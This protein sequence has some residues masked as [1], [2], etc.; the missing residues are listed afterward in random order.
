MKNF[1]YIVILGTVLGLWGWNTY[2]LNSISRKEKGINLKQ[3]ELVE[4]SKKYDEKI[5]EYDAAVDLEAIRREMLK[6]GFKPTREII[7]FDAD[8]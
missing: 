4:L 3:K 1:K 8:K 6:K 7:W 2:L 5:M